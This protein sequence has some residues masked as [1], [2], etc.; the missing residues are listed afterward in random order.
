MASPTACTIQP[1]PATTSTA[2]ANLTI[3][4]GTSASGTAGNLT[5]AGGTTSGTNGTVLLQTA[6]ITA[7]TL[8]GSQ[9]AT[10]TGV[11]TVPVIKNTAAQTTLTITGTGT[12]NANQPQQGSTYKV[13]VI[14]LNALNGSTSAYTF[15]TAFTTTPDYF[16]GTGATGS[17]VTVSTTTVSVT[18]TLATT[19]TIT[20]IGY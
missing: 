6:G 15:P 3:S 1:T 10:F 11:V 7:L 19:G 16:I 9:S 2:G 20:L 18:T 8:D 5:L 14:N 13:V 4:A 12:A 17:M